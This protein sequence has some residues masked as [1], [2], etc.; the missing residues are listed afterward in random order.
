MIVFD[1]NIFD[2]DVI[3]DLN[4][5]YKGKVISIKR[6]RLRILFKDDSIPTLLRTVKQP[7]FLTT[8]VSDFWRKMPAHST[9]CMICF[10]LPNE[11]IPEIPRLLRGVLRFPEFKTK[12]ARM[13][14][15]PQIRHNHIDYYA[16]GSKQI[17]TL[18]WP[19][20]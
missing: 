13:G 16:V 5:W 19:A 20:I 7:T 1:E 17:F 9:Y 4:R 18:N 11:R 3:D 15:I 6:L 8:N 10:D 12:A 2:Y 14:K